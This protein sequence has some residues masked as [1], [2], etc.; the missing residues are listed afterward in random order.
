MEKKLRLVDV[1]PNDPATKNVGIRFCWGLGLGWVRGWLEGLWSNVT[2]PELVLHPLNSC[3]SSAMC[4][5]AVPRGLGAHQYKPPP[6]PLVPW[7]CSPHPG[8]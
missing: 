3:G 5:Q 6:T 2:H 4:C 8:P 7:V 1:V